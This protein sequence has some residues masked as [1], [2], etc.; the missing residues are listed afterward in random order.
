MLSQIKTGV[1]GTMPFE[2]SYEE[3]EEALVCVREDLKRDISVRNPMPLKLLESDKVNQL[4]ALKAALDGEAF[5]PSNA[6]IVDVPKGGGGIRPAHQLQLRDQIVYAA[7]GKAML[8]RIAAEIATQEKLT[9]YADQILVNPKSGQWFER[10]FR[11]Y[12]EFTDS[13]IAEAQQSPFVAIA[14]ISAYYENISHA[15][16]ISELTRIGV[17]VELVGLLRQCLRSWSN[18]TDR[19]IP[20]GY[21]TSDLLA[22][23]YLSGLDERLSNMGYKHK[24][25]KDDVRI[26]CESEIEA[27]KAMRAFIA[28]ARE[29]TLH[30]QSAKSRILK[31]DDAINLFEGF[32]PLV[33]EISEDYKK[34]LEYEKMKT[35]IIDYNYVS[36]LE[37]MMID[38]EQ[39]AF[40][41][42]VLHKAY[43]EF[44]E[45]STAT[46][47][48][49]SA[50]R[51]LLNQ[52]GKARDRYAV[53]DALS[54]LVEYPQETTAIL[55]YLKRVTIEAADYDTLA[56][57]IKGPN[58]IYEFQTYQILEF[59]IDCPD[60]DIKSMLSIARD[61]SKTAQPPYVRSLARNLLGTHGVPS[62]L[63]RLYSEYPGALTDQEKADLLFC[64]RRLEASRRN[65][66]YARAEKDGGI[67]KTAIQLARKAL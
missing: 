55:N 41:V 17:S 8:P 46:S 14:D 7:I 60:P 3:L 4:G 33:A 35:F 12:R 20:Q 24:R 65:A 59:L 37:Q 38:A 30:V 15:F 66:L 42:V 11:P 45:G 64:L 47:F 67:I 29:R 27:K 5:N 26:F 1:S 43:H 18:G 49:K 57:F 32:M 6:P 61:F 9:D 62:D 52:L 51:Y 36:V 23:L 10:Y 16:L 25:Y 44:I 34:S 40:P 39:G 58:S 28:L 21:L 53:R 50:F 63:E 54:R 31:A 2:F 13:S 56:T 19:G 22:K 48:N